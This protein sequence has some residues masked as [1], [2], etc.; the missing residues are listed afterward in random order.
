VAVALEPRAAAS[1]SA[2]EGGATFSPSAPVE[3]AAGQQ[4]RVDNGSWPPS[5][6]P[7]DVQRATAWLRRQIAFENEPL[8]RVAA[9]FNRYAATPIEIDSAALRTLPVSGVF[10]ADDTE[11]F[12]A[13][14]RSLAGVQVEVTPTRIRVFRK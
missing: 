2:R 13:F 1:S 3:V 10:P 11:S 12:L 8:G 4:V 9:E 7:V 5:F 14:L 6:T